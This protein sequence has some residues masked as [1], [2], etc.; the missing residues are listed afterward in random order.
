MNKLI[1]TIL[2]V[3]DSPDDRFLVALAV[4]RAGG[5]VELQIAENG[6]K[7]IEYL[8]GRGGFS[9]RTSHGLPDLVLLDLK[10]PLKS[11]LEVLGWIRSQPQFKD[12]PVVILSS[13][14]QASDM[15]KAIDVGASAYFVKPLSVMQLQK[16]LAEIYEQWLGRGR[17]TEV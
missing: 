13:S 1:Q 8:E 15:E 6:E 2:H 4:R 7:A 5:P 17:L 12:L 11:G 10:L 9:D 16:Q 14:E 3:E